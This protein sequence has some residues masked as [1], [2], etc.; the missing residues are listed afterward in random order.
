MNLLHFVSNIH[1]IPVIVMTI[2][3][4]ALGAFWHRPFLFGKIWAREN[5]PNNIQVKINAPLIFGGTAIMHFIAIAALSAL[6]SGQGGVK[7]VMSGLFISIIWIVPAMGGTYLFA[8][9][10]LKLLAIDAGMYI[11]LFS[12]TGFI[13][14]IW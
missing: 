2:F 13:L 8:N 6:V 12:L 3:S 1:W 4:F 5:N 10:S 9:R 11:I 7:G 14:G